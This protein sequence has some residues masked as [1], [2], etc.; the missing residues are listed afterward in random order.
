MN[1]IFWVDHTCVVLPLLVPFWR[2]LVPYWFHFVRC[3]E[4]RLG[5]PFLKQ[6]CC[7]QSLVWCAAT[8]PY[9]HHGAVYPPFLPQ[10]SFKLGVWGYFCD[11][12]LSGNSMSLPLK[13][14]QVSE[15]PLSG[16]L[17]SCLADIP[18]SH[19]AGGQ[20]LEGWCS[21]NVQSPP[22]TVVEWP[23]LIRGSSK[24][25]QVC[26]QDQRSAFLLC[27]PHSR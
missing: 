7:G 8:T 26:Y 27:L 23:E 4:L 24:G 12:L 10:L 15:S 16:N 18:D 14:L 1:S 13:Y 25:G 5:I 22:V 17:P 20:Q 19:L 3:I 9:Y 21:V 2:A 6:S 11:R